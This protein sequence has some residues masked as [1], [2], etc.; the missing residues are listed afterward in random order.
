M[1]DSTHIDVAI[2]G[3]GIS[4]I[5]AA[6][7]VQTQAP[8]GTAYTIFESRDRIGGTWDLFKYPGIRSDSDL[9]TFG[10]PWRPWKEDKA[11]AEAPLIL[12]YMRESIQETGI[13][14][15]IQFGHKVINADWSTEKLVWNL[16]VEVGGERKKY[17][18]GFIIFGTGYYDYDNPLE[19]VINGIERFQGKVVHPQF[20]PEDLD[21]TDKNVVII[22]SGATA[23]TILPNIA[24]KAKHV[25]M[26]QRS[27]SYVFAIP[28]RKD[29][30]T[31]FLRRIF[32]ADV[33]YLINRMRFIFVGYLFFYFCRAFPKAARG[34]LRSVTTRNLPASI[35]HDPHFSP[36]YNP[37]EQRLCMAPDGDFYRAM[38]K[39]KAN[40]VTGAIRT[41]T[42]K[43]LEM[44]SG[45]SIKTD[46]IVTATGLK[47]QLA[48]GIKVSVDGKVIDIPSKYMW[49]GIM[50]QD[51]PNV[52]FVVGYTNASWTLGAD[53]TAQF[54]TRLLNTMAKK[55][56]RAAVPR[57]D[58]PERMK[59]TPMLNLNSTYI[60]KALKSMPKSGSA[61]P[62]KPRTNYVSDMAAAKYGNIEEGI[63]YLVPGQKSDAKWGN[64]HIGLHDSDITE[65]TPL[66]TRMQ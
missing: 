64:G 55:G 4:G 57:L 30:V 27:P 21:Y 26:V 40:V 46:I 58:H 17:T 3:A 49:K 6:Y 37:W 31:T 11:I 53:A 15:K 63:E 7:R 48:G 9:Y 22:G 1:A 54:V 33:A 50:L 24:E 42:E 60:Q 51:L 23:V 47:I 2:I 61:G 28:N 56:A 32:S 52:A 14:K 66:H 62:W 59:P 25:T 38:R 12:N 45:E 19:A 41:V 13:D 20:W 39:G 35:P 34:I 43:G 10:F 5:N 16:D 36:S 29:P 44:E 18:A 65:K 8:K